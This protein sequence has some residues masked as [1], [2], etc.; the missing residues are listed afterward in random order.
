MAKRSDG[1]KTRARILKAASEVFAEKGYRDATIEDIC[2]LAETNVAAINYHFGSKDRLYAEVWRDAFDAAM[3]AYPP[4]GGLGPQAPVEARLRGSIYS[5]VGRSVDPGRIGHAG[6]LLLR[7]MVH[8]TDVIQDI[9]RD[10]IQPLHERMC[11]MMSQLLGPE[12][13][14]ELVLL[15]AMSVVHQCLMIGIRMFTGGMPAVATF[16]MPTEKLVETLADHITRFSLAGV[17]AM[18]ED[19]EASHI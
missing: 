2:R 18:S 4:E 10:A 6:K 8:P 16:D 17:K 3:A 12:V 11:R 19:L 13:G 14:E 9:K 1:V 15:C 5:M 7:E